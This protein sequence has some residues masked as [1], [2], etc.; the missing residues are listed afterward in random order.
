MSVSNSTLEPPMLLSLYHLKTVNQIQELNNDPPDGKKDIIEENKA[1]V[2]TNIGDLTPFQKIQLKLKTSDQFKP[3]I[4]L[5]IEKWVTIFGYEHR[6]QISNRGQIRSLAKNTILIKTKNHDGYESVKLSDINGRRASFYVHRLVALHFIHNPDNKPLVDHMDNNHNN[7]VCSNLRWVTAHE[8]AIHYHQTQKTRSAIKV[9]YQYNL[10]GTLIA[11]WNN[12]EDLLTKN[13]MY[14]RSS[15]YQA[16]CGNHPV[17][18]YLWKYEDKEAYIGEFL[19]VAELDEHDFKNYEISCNGKVK[20]LIYSKILKP[21][22]CHG[23]ERVSLLD[24]KSNKYYNYYVHQLV[25]NRF[26]E[27]RNQD[28]NF[29]NHIDNN[30]LNNN[31]SNL[32]W[33]THQENIK[34]S[35]AKKVDQ[36][37][38]LTNQVLNTFDSIA[39]ACRHINKNRW[40]IVSCC[41]GKVKHTG[42]YI[43]KYHDS[44]NIKIDTVFDSL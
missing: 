34:H 4:V 19:N 22:L 16:I 9:I 10:E 30:K 28:R 20:S 35:C 11:K 3:T 5:N 43:W 39:D 44:S 32:E 27:G 8:N 36:I 18:G 12:Y 37:D 13:K 15:L 29:V 41:Q 6:Y 38:L 17:Y 24:T 14:K 26:V 42:G 7:N 21:A 33:V 23:Y 40:G 1:C 31:Y 2:N 25:A